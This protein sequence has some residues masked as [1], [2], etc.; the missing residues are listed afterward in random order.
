FLGALAE[1]LGAGWA[2]FVGGAVYLFAIAV[3]LLWQPRV[4]RLDGAALQA[5]SSEPDA[6]AEGGQPLATR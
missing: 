3:T 4:R 5:P 1:S 2:V 6:A